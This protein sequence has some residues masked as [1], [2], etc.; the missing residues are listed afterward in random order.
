MDNTKMARNMELEFNLKS[1]DISTRASLRMGSNMEKV[2]RRSQEI[3]YTKV[4][5]RLVKSMGMV[6]RRQTDKR[7]RVN[8]DMIVSSLKIK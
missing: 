7:R 3:I 5:S 6:V 1:M 4:N 2:N 8:S